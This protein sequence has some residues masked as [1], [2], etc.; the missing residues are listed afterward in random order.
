MYKAASRRIGIYLTGFI[1][2]AWAAIVPPSLCAAGMHEL[3][4]A[5]M[6]A[7]YAQGFSDFS[8]TNDG[9]YDYVKL[10]FSG[11]TLSTW[12]EMTALRMGYYS[13]GWDQ[14]WTGTGTP[15]GTVSLGSSGTDLVASEPYIEAKFSNITDPATRQLEYVRIGAKYLTGTI[16][17][18]FNPFVGTIGGSSYDRITGN[19]G[20]KTI[21]SDGS[22]FYL[23]LSRT[24][25][26]SFYFG[27][28]SHL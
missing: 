14:Q 24:A 13:G 3:S 28:G 25:G 8:L 17:A 7:F 10:N 26:Y 15:T 23:S 5:E 1:L 4:D 22:S 16:T 11:V 18:N 20:V 9:T 12:T 21:T 19:L 6:A 2:L 27:T